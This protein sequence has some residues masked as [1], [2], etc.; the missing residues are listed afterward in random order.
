MAQVENRYLYGPLFDGTD[1]LAIA[2]ELLDV[3]TIDRGTKAADNLADRLIMLD[4]A[5]SLRDIATAP[6]LH[7]PYR[8]KWQ[9]QKFVQ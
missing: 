3:R 4:I 1:L 2:E 9:D 7:S 8:T 6:A 5:R